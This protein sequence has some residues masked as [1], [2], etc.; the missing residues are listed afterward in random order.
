MLN[1]SDRKEAERL[2]ALLCPG[3]VLCVRLSA[4]GEV[5]EFLKRLAAKKE[6]A[7]ASVSY[8][9]Y[10]PD[11]CD[12]IIWRGQCHHLPLKGGQEREPAVW[13]GLT[14]TEIGDFVGEIVDYGTEFVSPLYEVIEHIEITLKKRNAD[15]PPRE[16]SEQ[17]IHAWA[18]ATQ[19]KN[20]PVGFA[21]SIL[22][23]ARSNPC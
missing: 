16:M 8:V 12:R 14:D 6:T 18:D 5:K 1:E 13:R 17:E 20:N 2:A 11:K 22:A 23:A 3:G 15:F 10:V 9:Q 4:V 21:R 7:P 19:Y